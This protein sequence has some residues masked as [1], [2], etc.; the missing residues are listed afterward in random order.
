[1]TVQE[2][3]TVSGNIEYQNMQIKLGGKIRGKVKVSDK[4]RELSDYK[5]NDK[6]A[7]EI[8]PPQDVLKDK[9][10]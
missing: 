5:K 3:G 7:E 8:L 6:K 2:I 1:M 9:N 10:T 4:I